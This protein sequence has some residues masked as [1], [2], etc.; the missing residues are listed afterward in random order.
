MQ[1]DSY[2]DN[3]KYWLI[4]LV[5]VG[6]FAL[7]FLNGADSKFISV[8]RDWIWM[9][10]MPAF[11]FVSGLFAKGL[12]TR[13]RG[14]RVNSICFYFIMFICFYCVV[15]L[16]R[17]V[18]GDVKF[19]PFH[20]YN[21]SW[22]F[23]ALVIL[24]CA[25]PFVAKLRG[26][27]KTV[28]SLSVLFAL[29]S[30]FFGGFDGFLTLGRVVNFAPF[31]F[32]GFFLDREICKSTV[33]KVQNRIGQRLACLLF[34]VVIFVLL[35]VAPSD[36]TGS[37]LDLSMGYHSFAGVEQGALGIPLVALLRLVWFVLASLMTFALCVLVP[38]QKT[39]YSVL[40][41]RTVQ[42]YILHPLIYL[43]MRPLD[44]IPKYI[45]PYIRFDDFFVVLV[46]VVLTFLLSLP[47]FPT[48][49]INALGK[50]IRID[51][52]ETGKK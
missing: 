37:L 3:L 20:V 40:G 27:I 7:T 31:Y 29:L 25:L 43:P 30:G 4:T 50:A 15:T 13:E 2:Y 23:L 45:S 26:G 6:H 18:F 14:L 35:W 46:A 28:V 12:Y 48:R 32:F 19:D 21:I 42:V 22:Y 39:F 17:N 11:L 52:F 49:W 36:L 10:H 38:A 9:F 8:L 24:G 51:K 1:R 5:V 33:V 34:L 16:L 44:I 41:S 47:S